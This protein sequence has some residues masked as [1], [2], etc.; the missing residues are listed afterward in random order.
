MSNDH[1]SDLCG[2]SRITLAAALL[3]AAA[4]LA[5]AFAQD[6][7]MHTPELLGIG[8]A[9]GAAAGPPPLYD[10]LGEGSYPV[11]TASAEVQAYFDQ[12]LKLAWGFNHAEARRAFRHAQALDPSC[13]MCFWGEAFVLGPN[14]NDGMHEAAIELAATA[15]A[16]AQ[17]LAAG[18]T[19]TEQDLIA[20][21]A[22]RY[23]ADPAA[24]R[25]AL[26]QA[27]ADAMQQVAAD[28]PDDPQVQVLYADAMMNL[29]P[30]DYWEP[31][32]VTPK[33]RALDIVASLEQALSVD[34]A[35]VAAAHLYIHAV[36]ASADPGRAEVYADRLRGAVPAAGHLVHMPAHIYT[37]VGRYADSV[38]VNRDAVAADEAFLAGAGDA[39]SPLYRY[40]YYPHNVHFLQ[41]SAQMA[42]LA[43]DALPAAEQLGQ[44]V[45]DAVASQ[46]GFVQAIKTAPYTAH[47]QFS[48]PETIL[49]LAD[50]GDSFPFV[51]GFWHYARGVAHARNGD[52]DAAMA[53]AQA[54]ATLIETADM[55]GL[56]A[57]YVP[58]RDL[59]S[60][61]QH[62][63]EAR[64]AQAGEDYA[65]AE[66]AVM[67][68]IAG[69]DAVPYMEPPYWYYPVHQTLGAILLQQ[70]KAEEAVAAFK[71]AL[72]ETPRNGWA[73]WGLA[74]AQRA[75]GDPGLAETEEAFKAA[76]LGDPALLSLDR[77]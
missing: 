37:R 51:K 28:H 71:Q 32:G 76:W 72:A 8:E 15:I 53:E 9:E 57:Q 41:T 38:A 16:Q 47:V 67:Q 7:T 74:E 64:I 44:V 75:A 61:A 62:L 43:E 12:G 25:V 65:G 22:Q 42:G 1:R 50:P 52:A 5:T 66:A 34:P 63:V 36:E 3:A 73:L 27:W 45:S 14:I 29:Q 11:T 2:L 23:S 33:G 49:A 13:A 68:A 20:A 39:A 69:E 10:G 54:I 21:L 55:S 30:W 17:S 70:G 56:E 40:G 19:D 26:N 35:H 6:H 18:A 60:I 48:E 24:D 77:L 31:D 46:V 4:P 58:A 59:L